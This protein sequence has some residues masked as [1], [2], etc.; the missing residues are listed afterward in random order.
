MSSI[1]AVVGSLSNIPVIPIR[2]AGIP[3]LPPTTPVTKGDPEQINNDPNMDASQKSK[4]VFMS[5]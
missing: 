4:H 2:P 5:V 1:N 3:L